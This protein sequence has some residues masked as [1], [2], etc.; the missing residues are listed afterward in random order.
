MDWT[1]RFPHYEYFST[2]EGEHRF[3]LAESTAEDLLL[4]E[5]IDLIGLDTIRNIR[6]EYSSVAGLAALRAEIGKRCESPPD[7]VM[8]TQGAALGLYLV[9]S[10]LARPKAVAVLAAPYFLPSYDTLI[11]NGWQVRVVRGDFDHDY[12]LDADVIGAALCPRTGLVSLASPQNPAGIVTPEATLQ[13]ILDRMAQR[14]PEAYLLVDETYREATYDDDEVAASAVNLSP[15]V[16]TC[17]SLS[18]A[19]GAPG[20]RTGWLTTPDADLR[21]RLMAAKRNMS[22]CDSSLTEQ[23]ATALLKNAASFIA[24]Y[25]RKVSAGLRIVAQW[26]AEEAD[27]LG[28][29]RPDAGA[30][31]C[32][33]LNPRLFDG[34]A[35]ATFW[36]A[37]ADY[38]VLLRP[39]SLFGE[40]DSYFRL[41]FGYLPVERLLE[42]LALISRALDHAESH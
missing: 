34:G 35:V 20:L 22:I 32:M 33:R 17:A 4:G 26:Q 28:W 40:D 24:R 30:I 8:T 10:E 16:I 36:Q 5:L 13:A 38:D 23:L 14:S 18:K 27:R 7:W 19:H 15:R 29:V 9:A 25:R 6:L 31:C 1:G 39:G 3:N 42:G 11:A 37:L 2:L 21:E 41:G 12:R